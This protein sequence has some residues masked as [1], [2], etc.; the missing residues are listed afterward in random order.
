MDESRVSISIY[1]NGSAG[2]ETGPTGFLHN[3]N[4]LHISYTYGYLIIHV[5]TGGSTIAMTDNGYM[6]L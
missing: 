6:S 2:G 1:R 5:A 3:V 4:A